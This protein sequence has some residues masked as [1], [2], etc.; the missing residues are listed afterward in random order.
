MLHMC[1]CIYVYPHIDIV[2]TKYWEKPLTFEVFNSLLSEIIHWVSSL[3]THQ[4]SHVLTHP[5]PSII[6][7]QPNPSPYCAEYF[8]E[9]FPKSSA[10]LQIHES[11]YDSN[12]IKSP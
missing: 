6:S 4:T 2:F 7:G 11:C 1:M 5:P 10:N 3:V 8:Q 12:H 9:S